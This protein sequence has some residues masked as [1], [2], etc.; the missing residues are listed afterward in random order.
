MNAVY[1]KFQKLCHICQLHLFMISP[2]VAGY[3]LHA[4]L[5]VTFTEQSELAKITWHRPALFL[6]D[7]GFFAKIAWLLENNSQDS[8]ESS[9]VSQN[10][11]RV[12]ER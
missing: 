2:M 1:G 9:Q 7:S 8:R 10:V 12:G 3:R 11:G 5:A 4:V 6:A